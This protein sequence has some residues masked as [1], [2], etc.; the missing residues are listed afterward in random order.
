MEFLQIPIERRKPSLTHY[1]GGGKEKKK[2]S[3]NLCRQQENRAEDT[4]TDVIPSVTVSLY[5]FVFLTLLSFSIRTGYGLDPGIH[6]RS[7]QNNQ[8]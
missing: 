3:D 1:S 5:A 2:K 6:M 7:C 8:I 4:K